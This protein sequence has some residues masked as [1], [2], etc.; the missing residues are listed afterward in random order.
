[1]NHMTG[2]NRGRPYRRG[3]VRSLL[4]AAGALALIGPSVALASGQTISATEG[5]QFSGQVVIG[6]LTT[7]PT[8]TISWGDGATSTST[9]GTG[10]AVSGVHAYAEEGN[11][12]GSVSG[13]ASPEPFTADV[14]DAPVS[15]TGSSLTA[16]AGQ[17]FTATV[18]TFSDA[19]PGGAAGDYTATIMWGD[20]SQ[21]PGVVSA[22]GRGFAVSGTHTYAAA[23]TYTTAL[24]IKDAGA[25]QA[26]VQATVNV[27][28]ATPPPKHASASFTIASGAVTP[29]ASVLFDAS[30]SHANG[31][32]V[33]SFHWTVGG[34]GV[35]GRTASATCSGDTS[36][37]QTSFAQVGTESITL[38]VTDSLGQ[39]TT[40]T[41]TLIVG[42]SRTRRRKGPHV[43]QWFLC[44][45]GLSD[46]AVQATLNGGPPAGC[47]DQAQ[48]GVGLI[49]A[50]GC[51]QD[52]KS[53]DQIPAPE[54]NIL[55]PH[56]SQIP[57]EA[58]IGSGTP[59]SQ[60]GVSADVASARGRSARSPTAVAAN[61]C[62]KC[63]F[64]PFL[65]STGE[66]R[67]NGL[68]ITPAPGAAV[69]IDVD[70][71]YLI[72]SNATISLLN[73]KLTLK[74]D[75]KLDTSVYAQNGDIPVLDT[76][77]GKLASNDPTVQKLVNLGGFILGGTLT[78]DFK[79]FYS[80][81]GASITLPSSFTDLSG[82]GVTSAIVMTADNTNGLVIDDLGINVPAVKFNKAFEFDKLGFC[83]QAHIDAVYK[84]TGKPDFCAQLTGADFGAADTTDS[85]S[86][87]ATGKLSLLGVGVDAAPPPSTYGIG[88]VDDNFDFGGAA[89]S[90]PDPGIPLGNSGV[91]LKSIG[92]SLGVDPTRFTGSI[93]LTAA[94]IISINGSLFMAFPS[95]NEPYTFTG[96]EL[97]LGGGLT[98]PT[99]TATNFTFAAGGDV[100]VTIP[101]VGTQTLAGGYVMYIFPDYLA[102]GGSI[103]F[104]P[105]NGWL[106]FS[107]TISGQFA[108]GSGEFDLEAT[109]EIKAL[110][111][112]DL[113]GDA[114][115][116][117][118]G[119]GGCG[120]VNVF[121]FNVSAGAG[122]K[123]GDS[124]PGGINL[125]IGSCDLG[126]YKVTVQPAH[127][128][129]VGYSLQLP[130]GLP[131]ETIKLQGSG[132]PPEV[133]I[134]GPGGVS[135][136]SRGQTPIYS[137]P[138]VIYPVPAENTTYVGILSPAAGRYTIAPQ[139]GSPPI[140]QLL[141]ADGLRPTVRGH[142][143]TRGGRR[144]LL[145]AASRGAGQRVLFFERAGQVF[146]AIG[147]STAG[148][149]T[150]AFTPAPGPAGTRQ[151]VAEITQNGAP[152]VLNPGAVGAAAYQIVVGSYRAPGPRR[153][154]RVVHLRV[155]HA[156]T[157]V[158]VTW[159]AVPG[160][161]RYAV[162]VALT[163]GVHEVY[164]ATHGTLRI[165]GVNGEFS[166]RVTVEAIGDGASTATGPAVARRVP[167]VAV[168]AVGG[169][170]GR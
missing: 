130:G 163:N 92:A 161:R 149:G 81:I 74:K 63:Y 101:V 1:M 133:T 103:Q 60:I 23:G 115:L 123:W 64:P 132:G 62:P 97:A 100:G 165:L 22:N 159:R 141:H 102:A 20:G 131:S 72:S 87:N 65:L 105:F 75:F 147:S 152:V 85:S 91:S 58:L 119:I 11:Y 142:V 107:S 49:E 169:R 16:I 5:Q 71:G 118:A 25:S 50:V 162:T 70:D 55:C 116:S 30:G 151:V 153:L 32:Q 13:C 21:S 12:S 36:Q 158:L 112:V 150:L 111:V 108:V 78:V 61:V 121:G 2:L 51:W 148:R 145:F 69:L 144:V 17:S 146:R 43:T 88:F 68:D 127:D 46:S 54:Y 3:C 140:A 73:G 117:N 157:S 95:S 41:H 135:A 134:T 93:G 109:G 57:C 67:V 53:I 120:T 9:P 45:R 139:A 129:A 170:R 19:D 104:D 80:E 154:G 33:T 56:I 137:K 40:V 125:M 110:K 166:G 27:S 79:G 114:V 86:W 18:A 124:I 98:L 52:L 99:P 126:P 47:Q 38:Q 34:P 48:Y 31:A 138:F 37:L 8:V 164:I 10:G 168:P 14:A 28:S 76:D 6:C 160:A 24:A 113:K 94:K 35:I 42:G 122:Y 4:A 143:L 29:G 84:K 136:T 90:F 155:E 128:A 15:A 59:P 89:V 26:S 82:N 156:G 44:T 66:V 39:T 83:Y 77:L 167:R 106:V 7:Q 96:N